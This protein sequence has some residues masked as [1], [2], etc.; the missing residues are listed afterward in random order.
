MEN[1]LSDTDFQLDGNFRWQRQDSLCLP[2]GLLPAGQAWNTFS[3]ILSQLMSTTSRLAGKFHQN[4]WEIRSAFHCCCEKE[5]QNSTW[6]SSANHGLG[7]NPIKP[8]W[9]RKTCC[10]TAEENEGVRSW[11]RISCFPWKQQDVESVLRRIWG[12]VTSSIINITHPCLYNM[13][14]SQPASSFK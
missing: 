11:T 5:K 14:E 2:Q 13:M 10:L 12:K 6:S 9:I 4:W 3:S 7:Q 8:F 1:D